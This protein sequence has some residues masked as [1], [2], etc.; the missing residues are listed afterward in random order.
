MRQLIVIL[1]MA[2]LFVSCHKDNDPIT[3]E[4]GPYFPVYPGS[5][6]KYQVNDS[7]FV[8]DS[9]SKYFLLYD[10]TIDDDISNLHYS[11]TAYVPWYYSSEGSPIGYTGPMFVYNGEILDDPIWGTTFWPILSEDTSFVFDASPR[12]VAAEVIDEM[13]AT[14]KIFNGTDSVLI[15]TGTPY[16]NN[17]V[18]LDRGIR[19]M[20]FEK[21]VGLTLDY[22]V[23]PIT[24]DTLYKKVLV[25]YYIEK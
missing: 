8:I 9:T 24:N 6:W 19:H 23:V 4:P 12:H 14:G 18:V 16:A 17:T 25:D 5:F 21:F 1:M 22:R 13:V 3:I 2:T 20:E 7:T 10:Y 11:S 15:L